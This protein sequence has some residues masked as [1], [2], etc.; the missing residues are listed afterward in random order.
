MQSIGVLA[1]LWNIIMNGVEPVASQT[2]ILYIISIV[3]NCSHNR[4]F[5]SWI[6]RHQRIDHCLLESIAYSISCWSISVH[7]RSLYTKRVANERPSLVRVDVYSVVV[8]DCQNLP[9]STLV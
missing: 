6:K 9:E 2:V 5:Y 8:D 4:F 3:G 1:V 7:C